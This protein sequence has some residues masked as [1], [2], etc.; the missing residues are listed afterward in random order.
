[1]FSHD[2]SDDEDNDD[3]ELMNN[4]WRKGFLADFTYI[5]L[6]NFAKWLLEPSF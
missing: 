6:Q 5:L 3:V 1:L 4:G 2:D